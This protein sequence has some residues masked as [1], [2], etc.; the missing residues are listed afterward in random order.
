MSQPAPE[1]PSNTRRTFLQRTAV[2]TAVPAALLVAG[3]ANE[4]HARGRG[5]FPELYP[6]GNSRNFHEIQADE[7]AHVN[8]LLSA[9]GTNARPEPTFTNLEQPDLNHF[10]S[11]SYA[12]ENTGVGAYL[13]AAPA[14]FDKGILASAASIALIEAYHSGYLNT[15]VNFPITP[16]ATPFIY[17][18]S[19]AQVIQNAGSFVTSLNGGPPLSFDPN[20]ANASPTND[21]AILN[22]ALVLEY[23]ER[24]FYNINVPK[25]FG[26]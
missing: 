12:F 3:Q 18:F 8:A 17:P 24:N 20:P 23:L 16:S 6:G 5:S 10:I 15:L 2:A 25:F 11:L 26:R 9:L 4:A 14:I 22:F 19:I 13:G 21:I 1:T 7:I